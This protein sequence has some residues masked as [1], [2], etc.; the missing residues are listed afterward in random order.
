M[1]NLADY[2]LTLYAIPPMLVGTLIFVLGVAVLVRERTSEVSAVFCLMTISAALWLV[3]TGLIFMARHEAAAARWVWFTHFGVSYLPSLVF[4]TS[5]ALIGQTDR[6]RAYIGAAFIFSTV[7]YLEGVLTDRLIIGIRRYDWGYY[8]QYGLAS[9]PY[10]TFVAATMVFSLRLL[11][12]AYR[13]SPPGR[14]KQRL[15]LF[16]IAFGISYLAMVD[17]LPA[18]GIGLYPFGYLPIF[19]FF[20]IAAYTIRRYHRVDLTLAFAAN[21]ILET[22]QGAVLVV[23]LEGA[24]RVANRAAGRLL[25][26]AESE[27]AGKS[28]TTFVQTPGAIVMNSRNLDQ[29][30]IIRDHEMVWRT[31]DDR[32]IR[33]SVSAVLLTDRG[34]QLAGMVYVATD[35]TER[36]R[37]EEALREGEERFRKL[38][39]DSPIGMMMVGHDYKFVRVNRALCEMVGY[40]ESELM[41]MTFMDITHPDD[42]EKDA[43]LAGQVFKGEIPTY[44]MEKRYITKNN[45]VIW[46]HLTATVI[47]DNTGRILY[48][49][50]MIE[51]IME[52][53]EAEEAL[54]ASRQEL[55]DF[56]DT[57]HDLIQNV[58]PDGRFVYVNR[59][60]MKALG[61]SENEVKH[62]NLF[63]IIHPDS[64]EHCE[65]VFR[66]VMRGESAAGIE[67]I[68]IAK[69][70]RMIAVEGSAS[71]Y[72]GHDKHPIT[73]AIFRD[74]TERKKWEEQLK[75]SGLHDALTDLPNR[76]LF[77]DRL[78]QAMARAAWRSRVVAVLFLDLDRF[79]EIND[80]MGHNIGDHLLKA[81]AQRLTDCVRQ[82]DT[83]SR[84]GGDEFTLVLNDVAQVADVTIVLKKIQDAFARPFI[85]EGRDFSVTASIGISIYPEDGKDAEALVKHADEAMY[86]AKKQG[87]NKFQF[88]SPIPPEGKAP[89]SA[90]LP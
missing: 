68:F 76:N 47:R 21:R 3:P 52:R 65:A 35:I 10:L 45:D 66:R 79:K 78:G 40:T 83:V 8:H 90:L 9:I 72:L 6:Y 55:Q 37:I 34:G 59:S 22:M 36:K 89:P 12:T 62:L 81:V 13:S 39:E 73:R 87:R 33:V 80:T 23:D 56:L 44:R 70:G 16:V 14:S 26:C 77:I 15:K 41:Q 85:L 5:L 11:W 20:L 50:G 61:Y 86:R 54:H 25:G 28:I 64:R 49:L 75:H 2:I 30:G 24:V 46:I 43:H 32:K 88:Y 74:V 7:F 18:F 60:W 57:A 48:G 29:E 38:F 63:D 31:N 19:A 71:C 42:I 53:K 27:L 1:A 84:L 58:G 69:D 4:L 82:G 67:A 17:Y 51:N